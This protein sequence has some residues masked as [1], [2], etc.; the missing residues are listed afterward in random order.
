[1]KIN[2]IQGI[3]EDIPEIL[4]EFSIVATGVVKAGEVQ[5]V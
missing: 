1:M 5:P 2:V 3:D 4:R